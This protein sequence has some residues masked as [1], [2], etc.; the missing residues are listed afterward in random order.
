MTVQSIRVSDFTRLPGPRYIREGPFSGEQYRTQRLAPAFEAAFRAGQTLEVDLDGM[1]YGYPASFL[2][3]SFGGLCR[4]W[5]DPKEAPKLLTPDQVWNQLSIK[6]NDDPTL[7][8]T[9]NRY[10]Q[11]ANERKTT[12]R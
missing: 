4:L 11:E 6:S 10:I 2:E 1:K 12:G 7:V 9:V 3:E 5:T 8:T